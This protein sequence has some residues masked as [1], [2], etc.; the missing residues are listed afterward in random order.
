MTL[1]QIAFLDKKLADLEQDTLVDNIQVF[2]FDVLKCP[3]L[4]KECIEPILIDTKIVKILHDS[5]N[6]FNAFERCKLFLI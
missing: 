5:K 3:E 2:F 1:V 4:V 6:D